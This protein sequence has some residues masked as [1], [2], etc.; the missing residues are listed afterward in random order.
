MLSRGGAAGGVV[1]P[2][3]TSDTP[4]GTKVQKPLGRERP[5]SVEDRLA[6]PRCFTHFE[7]GSFVRCEQ[8]GGKAKGEGSTCKG[9]EQDKDHICP[10]AMD[11]G[12]NDDPG[13]AVA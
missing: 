11:K 4:S 3:K 10:H 2:A 12:S 1:A 13:R 8:C 6:L 9:N 7:S 5:N